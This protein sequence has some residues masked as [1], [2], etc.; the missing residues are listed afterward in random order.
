VP[1]LNTDND[2]YG[3]NSIVSLGPS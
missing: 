2:E 3:C 1:F